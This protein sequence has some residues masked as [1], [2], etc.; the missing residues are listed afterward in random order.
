MNLMKSLRSAAAVVMLFSAGFAHAGLYQFNVTGDYTAS[1]QLDS[2]V[3]PDDAGDGQVFTL[4]DVEGTFPGSGLDLVELSFYH[5]DQ[6]GG[7]EIYDL[8]GG[9]GTLL[10]S[11]GSQLY[12]GSESA[13]TFTLGT[14]ALTEYHGSSRYT[15]TVT[16]LAGPVTVPEPATGAMLLG[17]L[18]LMYALRKR[19]YGN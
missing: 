18:G 19:R 3:A 16:D 10:L 2:T 13:P 17:G 11:D 7:L 9:M 4:W 14:F 12:T 5:A 15:L 1:W 8:R 6:G